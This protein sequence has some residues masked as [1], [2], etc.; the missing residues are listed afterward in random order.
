MPLPI[1]WA[2]FHSKEEGCLYLKAGNEVKTR[3]GAIL[4]I[5]RCGDRNTTVKG[6]SHQFLY[7]ANCLYNLFYYLYF[8]QMKFLLT[9]PK[10]LPLDAFS[11]DDNDL[12]RRFQCCGEVDG[13]FYIWETEI[14]PYLNHSNSMFN[15]PSTSQS[16]SG[17]TPSSIPINPRKRLD[18]SPP[19]LLPATKTARLQ[20]KKTAVQEPE[21]VEADAKD[22]DAKIAENFLGDF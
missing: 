13:F 9:N 1:L 3:Y 19:N 6:L 17:A 21:I 11:W 14:K 10:Q 20:Q 12:S 2:F 7:L 22:M 5:R 18:E 16:V 15:A 4:D 8:L